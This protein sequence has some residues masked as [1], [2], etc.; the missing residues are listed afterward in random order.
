MN[1]PLAFLKR[2]LLIEASYRF[3]FVFQV[4]SVLFTVASYY[5]LARFIGSS[6]VPGLDAYGGDYFAF[7]LIGV[8]LYDY[9]GTSLNAFS[10]SI[11]ESQLTGTL[12]ALLSTQT[13]L[14]TVILSSSAYPFLWTSLGVVA[15]GCSGYSSLRGT[16]PRPH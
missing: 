10:R 15:S 14:P 11:R 5:F 9:L 3:S 2:D 1:K 6:V 12:E 8:A 16:G 7:V 13:S 4:A